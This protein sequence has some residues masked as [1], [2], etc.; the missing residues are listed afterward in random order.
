MSKPDDD[1]VTR[2]VL[3]AYAELTGTEREIVFRRMRLGEA[4]H[5][6]WREFARGIRD[7]RAAMQ[8]CIDEEDDDAE[9]LR[10]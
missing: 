2:Y 4:G 6:L 1:A 8:K 9:R 7:A 10:N 5:P 3:D